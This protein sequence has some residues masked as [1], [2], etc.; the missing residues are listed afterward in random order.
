MIL[1]D[2]K[3]NLDDSNDKNFLMGQL[4]MN[5]KKILIKNKN[6]SEI[7]E[8]KQQYEEIFSSRSS[9]IESNIICID[10]NL[11]L[12]SSL[13]IEEK[14]KFVVGQNHSISCRT[15]LFTTRCC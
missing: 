13:N 3:F 2:Y 14:I 6:F 4:K 12:A 5:N 9:D 11:I 10:E 8:G 1:S 15:S 7:I